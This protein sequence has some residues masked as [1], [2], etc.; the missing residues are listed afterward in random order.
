MILCFGQGQVVW[1]SEV[2]SSLGDEGLHL[3]SRAEWEVAGVMLPYFTHAMHSCC[4][5][6]G[7]WPRMREKQ[8][9][10]FPQAKPV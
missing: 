10:H 7:V 5:C 6:L 9:I 3:R 2:L 1:K 4:F 8:K